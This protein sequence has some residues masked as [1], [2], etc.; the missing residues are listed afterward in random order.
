MP[1]IYAA[2]EQ[3]NAQGMAPELIGEAL[4]KAGW[5]AEMVHRAMDAWLKSHGRKLTV[6]GFKEWVKH[7]R[8]KARGSVVVVV[9]VAVVVVRSTSA[10]ATRVKWLPQMPCLPNSSQNSSHGWS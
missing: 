10:A 5:P 6:T 4:I 3:A 2:I 7:Y 1:E 8:K 9:F